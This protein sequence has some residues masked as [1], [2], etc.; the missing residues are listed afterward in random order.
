VTTA[1]STTEADWAATTLFSGVDHP[2]RF[3][4]PDVPLLFGRATTDVQLPVG[5]VELYVGAG[6][7]DRD[8]GERISA[9]LPKLAPADEDDDDD[10]TAESSGAGVRVSSRLMSWTL[11]EHGEYLRF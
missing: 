11:C 8:G 9:N 6:A 10:T 2:L 4:G 7:G 5:L 3:G 1:W